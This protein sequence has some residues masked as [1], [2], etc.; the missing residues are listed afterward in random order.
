MKKKGRGTKKD[1]SRQTIL[2]LRKACAFALPCG[3]GKHSIRFVFLSMV[4]RIE[5]IATV[6]KIFIKE[7][8]TSPYSTS[9][10]LLFVYGGVR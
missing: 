9:K 5:A 7:A 8:L 1:C 2:L 3:Y 4:L 6:D 10:S